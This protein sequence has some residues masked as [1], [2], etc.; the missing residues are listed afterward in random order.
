MQELKF[1]LR[2]IWVEFQEQASNQA[3]IDNGRFDLI[4]RSQ[5]D[6]M[7]KVDSIRDADRV[8]SQ[9]TSA[10]VSRMDHNHEQMM[11]QLVSLFCMT[12]IRAMW[13]TLG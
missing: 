9:Q 3:A 12:L 11:M 4:A 10:I 5:I 1:S 6:I 2:N 13:L 7:S 8:Y